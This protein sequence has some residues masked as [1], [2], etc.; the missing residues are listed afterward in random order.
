MSTTELG[1]TEPNPTGSGNTGAD[2]AGPEASG[3]GTTGVAPYVDTRRYLWAIGL[4]VPALPLASA[5]LAAVTGSDLWW[6]L[7]P[8]FI[9]LLIP[10]LDA[11]LGTDTANPPEELVAALEADH[12]Y[13]W[14]TYLYL[15]L[16]YIS[17]LVG[18][19]LFVDGAGSWVTKLAIAVSVG[20]VGGIG[21]A[22]AHELG[23]KKEKVE[24]RLSKFVLAQ[25]AYGHFYVEH[26]RGHHNRVATPED[27]ASSRMGE[28]FWA[29]LPRT[30]FGSLR[31]AW[32]LEAKRLR[33]HGQ[34]VFSWRN[35][36]LN[37][38][39]ITV[40]LFAAVTVWL[41]VA[42]VPFL[43]IQAVFG[44]CLLEVVNYVEHYGLLRQRLESGR[45]ERC[46][47]V[48]SWNSNHVASNVALYNLERHSDHHAHPTRRYQ[49]LRHFGE[50]PQLPNG[51]GLMIGLAYFPPIWRR[52][53]DHRVV[54][55]YEGD[56]SLANLAPSKREQ[57]LRRWS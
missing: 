9:Y 6:W 18:A 49:S 12:Y 51:Y 54:E 23:H 13:R 27:P 43:V 16:Q 41:G 36:V 55:H 17:F 35:D 15:P 57:L 47:P 1:P 33:A 39:A 28:S 8:G 19:W 20:G 50:S 31:S 21:I 38:W 44:F 30:V 56:L 46:R 4:L 22:N 5:G 7:T 34:R 26:N 52:M 42:V 29:F 32:E 10:V 24:R 48:H 40:V 45:Y 25:T 14:L 2:P 11:V 3:S 37:S 53:M